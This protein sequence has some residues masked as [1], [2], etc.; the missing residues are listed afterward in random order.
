MPTFRSKE[1]ARDAWRWLRRHRGILALLAVTLPVAIAFL[2]AYSAHLAAL[3]HV[4]RWL[5]ARVESSTPAIRA[6]DL[7]LVVGDEA[8]RGDLEKALAASGYAAHDNG[9]PGTFRTEGE[10]IVIHAAPTNAC[11][12]AVVRVRVE[13]SKI[14][15][16]EGASGE[17]R[18][19]ALLLGV[20]LDQVTSDDHIVKK[21]TPI[22]YLPEHVPAAVLAAEDRRFYDHPGVDLRAIARSAWADLRAGGVVQGGSTITQQLAKNVFLDRGRTIGRKIREAVLAKAIETRLGKDEILEAYLNA[23]YLGRI[24]SEEI[25][26]VERAAQVYFGKSAAC[27]TEPEALILAGMIRAPNLYSPRR[28]ADRAKAR[29]QRVLASTDHTTTTSAAIAAT[30]FL[31]ERPQDTFNRG[32]AP[33]FTDYALDTVGEI[34]SGSQIVATIDPALQASAERALREGLDRLEETSGVTAQGAIVVLEAPT[35]R[36]LAMVGGRSHVE[37]PFNRAVLAKRQIGSLVKPLLA[38]T[39]FE[40]DGMHP[41]TP[42]FDEPI[43][44]ETDDGVWRPQNADFEYHG[45]TSMRGAMEHSVNVPFVVLSR[46]IGVESLVH[47]LRRVGLHVPAAHPAVALGAV[48]ASPLEVA[49]AFATIANRGVAVRPYAVEAL[50]QADGEV[51]SFAPERRV[52]ASHR[53]SFLVFDMMRG[54]VDRGTGWRARKAGYSYE[55]AGKT[56][57]SDGDRDLWFVGLDRDRVGVVWIGADAP[58]ALGAS[59]GHVT[60][61]IWADAMMGATTTQR[62]RPY[63][64][65]NDLA[66]QPVCQHSGDLAVAGCTK[67]SHE[68]LPR[69]AHLMPCAMHTSTS[70]IDLFSSLRP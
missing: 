53:S 5:E 48:D 19:R 34:P 4:D 42:L 57:T 67:V 12:E 21:W 43:A 55:L 58:T 31:E 61:A 25:V 26:G 32:A 11:E 10:T 70:A 2:A 29:A 47:T 9:A 3:R 65:P 62:P 28:H 38:L 16:V 13:A 44:I 35:G 66:A 37:T 63:P 46:M 50:I 45:R 18:D 33:Y 14:V 1:R 64:V 52:V 30:R 54:V 39:A 49:A 6:P 7:L 69:D 22:E 20:T 23:I 15:H 17:A 36:V 41:R 68:L 51:R 60:P 8:P 56:G 24:G 27:L 40:H 59:S